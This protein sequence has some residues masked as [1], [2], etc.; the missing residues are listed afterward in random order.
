MRRL[1]SYRRIRVESKINVEC[2]KR[3]KMIQEYINYLQHNKGYSVQTCTEYRKDLEKFVKWLRGSTQI[4]RWGMVTKDVIDTWVWDMSVNDMSPCTIKR[5]VSALRGLYQ[6]AWVKGLCQDNPA[7]Y[8]STP[9]KGHRLP[10]TADVDKL[11]QAIRNTATEAETKLALAIMAE[12]GVRLGELLEMRVND[13]NLGERSIVVRGKGNKERK[14]YYG[15]MTAELIGCCV[16]I[17]GGLLIS[18]SAREL[19][20]KVHAATGSS[21]HNIRHTWATVMLNN[22]CPLESISKLMGHASVKTTEI[23]AEVATAT[24]AADYNKY[25]P[26]YGKGKE[27]ASA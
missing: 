1:R 18:S 2:N 11:W 26:N 16:V 12:T 22:G 4:E 20:Y 9:K 25:K 3:K 6:Y 8:V 23:Y 14:V 10:K 27:R 17:G 5:R 19:R 13:V 15:D 24:L 21:P 7:K